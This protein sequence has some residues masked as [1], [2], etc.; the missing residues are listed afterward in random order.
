MTYK[1][2]RG[3]LL[4][5]CR[6]TGNCFFLWAPGPQIKNAR[7]LNE[8]TFQMK[9]VQRNPCTTDKMPCTTSQTKINY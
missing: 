3:E 7:N 5:E 2:R 8:G 4:T 6:Q 9:V 1:V